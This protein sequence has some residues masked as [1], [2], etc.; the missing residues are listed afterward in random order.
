MEKEKN[1]I[2]F[3][4]EVATAIAVQKIGQATIPEIVEFMGKKY[5]LELSEKKVRRI[6]NRFKKR[7]IMSVG[8]V[9]TEDGTEEAY[10]MAKPHFKNIPETAQLKDLVAHEDAQSLIAELEGKE[11]SGTK[12]K[13][14]IICD[15]TTYELTFNIKNFVLGGLPSE[16]GDNVNVLYRKNEDKKVFIPKTWF[17]GYIRN[18]AR[19]MNKTNPH[20][21]IAFSEGEV[22]LNGNKITTVRTIVEKRG[23]IEHEALPAGTKIH[24]IWSVPNKGGSNA[25]NEGE[26]E[27]FLKML[28]KIRISGLGAYNRKYGALELIEMKKV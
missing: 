1:K 19:L 7:D 28:G 11:G 10:S 23:F 13:L 25:F 16:K 20:R 5:S 6:C 3:E 12:D 14:P 17:Y 21:Y 22:E 15:Y 8:Y 18:N 2:G 9:S 27:K 24:T 4:E 26:F